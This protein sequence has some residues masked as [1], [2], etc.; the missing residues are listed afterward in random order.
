MPVPLAACEPRPV[1]S[2]LVR[3]CAGGDG[4]SST[5]MVWMESTITSLRGFPESSCRF[6]SVLDSP[7]IVK[8]WAVTPGASASALAG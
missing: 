5:N 1:D 7:T 3:H 2:R 6:C 8:S 4:T